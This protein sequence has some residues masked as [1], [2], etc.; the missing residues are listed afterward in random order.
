LFEERAMLERRAEEVLSQEELAP[1]KWA[2]RLAP[3]DLPDFAGFDVGRVYQPGTGMMAGDFYDVFRVAPERV[4]AVIGDVTG[5][6]I[7]PSITAFQAK[8]LLRVFLRQYRD[9]AQALEELNVQMGA[10]ARPEEFISLLV[11]VFDTEAGTLRFA[12]AGHPAGWL[13]HDREVQPLRAT[14]PLLLLDPDASYISR[15]ITLESGDLLLT[16]TDGLAE[17]RDGEALFGEERIASFLR[18][19]PGV[20]P[21]V[22][23]KTLIEAARDFASSPINDDIAIL[24]IRRS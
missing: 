19:D 21:D 24:A 13:W 11:T 1:R 6:G 20:D 17:A 10:Q 2:E 22:L 16:Y 3:D 8:Y 12:S 5:H 23:C 9:P 15:E 14:G 7:E 4:V 18:R